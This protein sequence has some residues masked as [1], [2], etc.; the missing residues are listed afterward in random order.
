MK[1]LGIL[2]T[3]AML[4]LLVVAPA[5]AD[6]PPTSGIVVRY[7]GLLGGWYQ[8]DDGLC[9]MYGFDVPSLCSGGSPNYD[10]VSFQDITLP[11]YEDEL[12]VIR[13][14]HG[15]VQTFVY[16]LDQFIL[17]CPAA[18]FYAAAGTTHLN[19][20]DN[21][22]F[23]AGPHNANAWGWTTQGFL[24][25]QNGNRMRYNGVLR[26]TWK[27]DGSVDNTVNKVHLH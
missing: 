21:D 24:Y 16:P 10:V 19:W 20:T 22:V 27:A 17:G 1:P 18:P 4:L 26:I 5:S 9:A 3:V 14:I 13:H 2:L 8:C 7:D 6:P 11:Q 12:R 23:A 25:D 15:D